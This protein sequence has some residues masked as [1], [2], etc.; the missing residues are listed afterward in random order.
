MEENSFAEDIAMVSAI[1]RQDP[2]QLRPFRKLCSADLVSGD[3]ASN[4]TLNIAPGT[5]II[6]LNVEVVSYPKITGAY[7]FTKRQAY[8]YADELLL[9]WFKDGKTLTE[10]ADYHLWHGATFIVVD[11]GAL[12]LAVQL[13]NI[14]PV[15]DSQFT[16][17]TISGLSMPRPSNVALRKLM[18]MSMQRL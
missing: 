18:A 5:S 9:Q 10:Q 8:S 16:D 11:K 6:I 1:T 3:P 12:M 4:F 17:I 13:S 7:D 15:I 14:G 2:A